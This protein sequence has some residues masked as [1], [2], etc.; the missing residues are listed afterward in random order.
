MQFYFRVLMIIFSIISL[1]SAK[2][3]YVTDMTILFGLEQSS[4]NT[5]THTEKQVISNDNAVLTI[6]QSKL[7]MEHQ[8]LTTAI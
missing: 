3:L 8:R 4:S 7:E 5:D 1:F 2:S 6:D